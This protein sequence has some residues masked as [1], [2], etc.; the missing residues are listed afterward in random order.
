MRIAVH[1]GLVEE[2][3]F[4]AC[5]RAAA[6]GDPGPGEWLHRA[7]ERAYRMPEGRERDLRFARAHGAAFRRMGLARSMHAVFAAHPALAR[8]DGPVRV[9]PAAGRPK[10]GVDLHER[11]G[12][13]GRSLRSVVASLLPSTLADGAE[14]A[15]RLHREACKTAD[16]LDPA[17][18]W[19][20]PAPEPTPA[21]REQVRVRYGAAWDAWTDGRLARR[22][23][24]VP[25]DGDRALREFSEAF[26]PALGEEGAEAAFR[27]LR[28]APTLAHADLLRFARD[29]A[30]VPGAGPA[31]PAPSPR[32]GP[33]PGG[34]C[35]FC[36]FPTH[37]WVPDLDAA[38]AALLAVVRA[39]LPGWTSGQGICGQC[40][41]VFAAR[42]AAASA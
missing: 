37:D 13:D 29:P 26:A 6:L 15:R 4:L 19:E 22:G 10:E 28:D 42:P 7:I 9:G 34:A 30:T 40:L 3:V 11:S 27:A 25:G 32:A 39:D 8:A 31:R 2:A 21:R 36:R 14:T 33:V 41:G 16:L 1:P 35:P 38:P 17:F 24:P 12:D 20:R 18:G 5:R 23:L